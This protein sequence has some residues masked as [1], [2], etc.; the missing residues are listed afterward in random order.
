[1]SLYFFYK[2]YFSCQVKFNAV[3]FIMKN[4]FFSRLCL[5]F[6]CFFIILHENEINQFFLLIALISTFFVLLVSFVVLVKELAHFFFKNFNCYKFF[7]FIFSTYFFFFIIFLYA[8]LLI[9]QHNLDL[10]LFEI[11]WIRTS[12]AVKTISCFL[13]FIFLLFLSDSFA[14]KNKFVLSHFYQRILEFLPSVFFSLLVLSLG[15][16]R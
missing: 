12:F 13:I 3:K 10:L 8:F 11:F 4:S 15:Y 7:L 14:D 1:M 5:F 2:F 9:L 16:Y 6:I